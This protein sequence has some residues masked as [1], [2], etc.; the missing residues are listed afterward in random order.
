MQQEFHGNVPEAAE[1]AWAPIEGMTEFSWR[2]RTLRENR[3]VSRQYAGHCVDRV[4]KQAVSHGFSR[5]PARITR[6]L[7]A[8]SR[9]HDKLDVWT[10]MTER[11]SVKSV[12]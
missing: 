3:D 10:Q 9:T 1:A 4:S 7:A 12:L 2:A 11:R 6:T 8:L 5:I